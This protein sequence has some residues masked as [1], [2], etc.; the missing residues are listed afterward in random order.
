MGNAPKSHE[1]WQKLAEDH[2]VKLDVIKLYQDEATLV[3]VQYFNKTT[4][5]LRNVVL[6]F[7]TP[8]QFQSEYMSEP[9]TDIRGNKIVLPS[10]PPRSSVC[11]LQL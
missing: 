4:V 5:S 9:A 2:A 11:H 8:S 10:L 3:V 1:Q 7:E 6:D